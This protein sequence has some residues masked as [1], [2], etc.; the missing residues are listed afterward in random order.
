MLIDEN[1]LEFQR[2]VTRKA[3]KIYKRRYMTEL[4][5]ARATIKARTRADTTTRIR[6]FEDN[7]RTPCSECGKYIHFS[8]RDENWE[9][10]KEELYEAFADWHHDKC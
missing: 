8:S 10:E 6:R 9:Q 4:N 1:S 2:A 5:K 3:Q 7:F